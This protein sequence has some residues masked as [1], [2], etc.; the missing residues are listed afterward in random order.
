MLNVAAKTG[1]GRVL[2]ASVGRMKDRMNRLTP[3]LLALAAVVSAGALGCADPLIPG[4]L[5]TGERGITSIAADGAF[6]YWTTAKGAVKKVSLDG[7]PVTT[8]VPEP[9]QGLAADHVAVDETQVVWT[10]G[11]TTVAAVK[12]DGTD[13][14]LIVEQA[15]GEIRGLTLDTSSVYWSVA[16]GELRRAPRAGGEVET[17][18]SGQSKPSGPALD[19]D[20]LF[21]GIETGELLQLSTGGGAPE[22]LFA[23]EA[24]PQRLAV[25]TDRLYWTT[26]GNGK[27]GT[28]NVA[29]RSGGSARVVA[30]NQAVVDEVAGDERAVFWT[31]FDGT[32][33]M[34]PLDGGDPQAIVKGPEGKV[35]LALTWDSVYWANGSDGELWTM[36]KPSMTGGTS[37]RE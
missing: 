14:S 3:A 19:H 29:D 9:A 2:V 22:K 32:V 6:I 16:E 31:S 20:R 8:I 30:A 34:V 24:K 37:V 26:L 10:I 17:L 7:G 1:R 21:W 18:A 28:V 35:S 33:S 25:T 15:G 5:V 36:Y 4:P 12:K 11:G 27:T 23:G 13:A